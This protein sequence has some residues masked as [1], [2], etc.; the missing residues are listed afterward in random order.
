LFLETLLC[1]RE[2]LTLSYVA[3][4]PLTGDL[5]EPSSVIVELEEILRGFLP[6][7]A[8]AKFRE[9][10]PLGRHEDPHTCAASPPAAREAQAQALGE[11]LRAFTGR[12]DD[13]TL[14]LHALKNALPPALYARLTARLGLA[15]VPPRIAVDSDS[16]PAT[17]D[18]A[19]E[20]LAVP[21]SAL[22]RFLE[23]PLQGSASFMLRMR[24]ETD[25]D[26]T[27]RADE[28][29]ATPRLDELS[30]LRE[31]FLRALA[32][33][34]SSLDEAQ[35]FAGYDRAAALGALRGE[36]PSGLFAVAE[37]S[38]HLDVL[39]S[40]LD[41]LRGVAPNGEPSRVRT[42]R[43][44]HAEEH[45]IVDT[46]HDPIV[47][48]L[49]LPAPGGGARRVQVELYGKTEAI[50]ESLPGSVVLVDRGSGSEADVRNFRDSLKGFFDHALLAAAG[51]A[52]AAGREHAVFVAPGRRRAEPHVS[53]FA[54]LSAEDARA[55]LSAVAGDLLSG[56]HSYLLPCEAV[57][58]LKNSKTPMTVLAAVDAL[59]E[60]SRWGGSY[61]SKY[62][63]VRHADRFEPPEEAIAQAMIEK[64]F[65]PFFARLQRDDAK[66]K[67]A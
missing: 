45:A 21:V 12:D 27:A 43:F 38:G 2:R 9:R 16:K 28:L 39:G 22:R 30:L 54:A 25:E 24:E 42:F 18:D 62:G 31:V 47:L 48:P 5:L 64:R 55:W 58:K 56:V 19:G 65:G 35:L 57:Y 44:G 51:L 67:R 7:A 17:D 6:P 11:D 60:N 33:G 53:R 61:S 66:R 34:G 32:E 37:R 52:P 41:T 1:A 14:G 4:D 13:Q 23:C 3:R 15:P 10:F 26:V 50:V 63:P 29:F 49:E 36:M 59:R 8:L 46:L 40:W 20:K